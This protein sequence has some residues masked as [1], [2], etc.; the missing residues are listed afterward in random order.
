MSKDWDIAKVLSKIVEGESP[1]TIDRIATKISKHYPEKA[2][3]I[4][5][6]LKEIETFDENHVCLTSARNLTVNEQDE[7]KKSLKESFGD[8]FVEFKVDEDI[9]GGVIIQKGD[10]VIDN[11]IR[12]KVGQIVD[13]INLSI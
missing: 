1:E 5:R 3:V 8:V 6:A 10:T 4:L 9:I 7:A 11:S 13:N 2:P 12:S